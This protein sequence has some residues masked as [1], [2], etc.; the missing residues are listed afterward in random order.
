M[1]A[2]CRLWRRAP[3]WR[4][5]L[6]ATVAFAALAAMFPPRWAALP[7]AKTTTPHF[8]LQAD[9]PLSDE[10]HLEL[11]GAQATRSGIIPFSGHKLPLPAGSWQELALAQASGAS[12][13]QVEL[14]ARIDGQHLTG[15]E[16]AAAPSPLSNSIG[17]FDGNGPCNATNTIAQ[18]SLPV[19]G[20]NPLARE[21]WALSEVEMT[22]DT[23]GIRKD[24]LIHRGLDRLQKMGVQVPDHM[25]VLSYLRTDETGWM[26]VFLFLPGRHADPSHRLI[27]WVRRFTPLLHKGWESSL[28]PADLAPVAHDPA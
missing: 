8:A 16:M 15:L 23:A 14:L 27:A 25:M 28:T 9:P 2:V 10:G 7:A 4:F 19:P 22:G 18:E 13:T 26:T 1:S 21:C 3:V 11:P 20:A 17:G 5:F 24:E 6:F 12:A